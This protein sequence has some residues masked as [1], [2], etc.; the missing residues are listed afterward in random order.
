MIIAAMAP[1]GHV[2][3]IHVRRPPRL[4][5]RT[6]PVLPVCLPWAFL[7]ASGPGPSR[8]PGPDRNPNATSREG[9]WRDADG[10]NVMQ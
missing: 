1:E 2:A 10:E 4:R 8:E 3:S 9:G 6:R 5:G 7:P